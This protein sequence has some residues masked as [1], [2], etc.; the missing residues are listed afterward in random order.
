MPFKRTNNITV[1]AIVLVL[2]QIQSAILKIV[3]RIV[4]QLLNI[5]NNRIIKMDS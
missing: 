4:V 5:A 1:M 3:I 2:Y